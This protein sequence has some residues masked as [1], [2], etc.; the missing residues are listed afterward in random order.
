MK[1]NAWKYSGGSFETKKPVQTQ[2]KKINVKKR[3]KA[4]ERERKKPGESL[5]GKE[6]L[7]ATEVSGREYKTFY[8]FN[9]NF[10][11]RRLHHT[12]IVSHLEG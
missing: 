8:R 2:E 7:R 11:I 4:R 12:A 3:R 10:T 9:L 5:G 1:G 6:L